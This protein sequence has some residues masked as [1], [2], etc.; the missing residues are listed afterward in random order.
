MVLA[1]IIDHQLPIKLDQV[2]VA[3][4]V[5]NKEFRENRGVTDKDTVITAVASMVAVVAAVV[6]HTAVALAARVL[7]DL[8]GAQ[9][10]TTQITQV[11]TKRNTRR[12]LN[13]IYIC[14]RRWRAKWSTVD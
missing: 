6:H 1:V 11:N 10:V 2:A 4:Q 5:A 12:F 3:V 14:R 9:A 7:F 13:V 8:Y